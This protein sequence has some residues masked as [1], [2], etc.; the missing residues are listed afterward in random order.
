MGLLIIRQDLPLFSM[1]WA[2][3]DSICLCLSVHICSS[4]LCMCV[5]TPLTGR[6]HGMPEPSA[7]SSFMSP[8][9]FPLALGW[10]WLDGP[11]LDSFC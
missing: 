7:S 10:S 5:F 1:L 4:Q 8:E 11:L 9:C 6:R 2:M 3:N